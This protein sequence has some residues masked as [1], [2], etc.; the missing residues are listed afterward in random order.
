MDTIETMKD[1][2]FTLVAGAEWETGLAC[3]EAFVQPAI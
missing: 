1:K 3:A 2:R